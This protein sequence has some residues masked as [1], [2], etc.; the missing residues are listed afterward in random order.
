GLGR[1]AVDFV[2]QKHVRE[3][4]TRHEG[5]GAAAGGGIF[6]DDVGA[7]DVGRHKVRRELDALEVQAENRGDGSHQKGL[8]STG[9][10][11]DE[12]VDADEQRDENLFDYLLLADDHA[13][14]L[15]DDI[16]L[17]LLEAR[18]PVFNVDRV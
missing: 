2:S 13:M 15:R 4:G 10:S 12:T 11:G 14:H 16:R 17:H 7:G 18:N 3:N 5:P 8:S 6:F 1:S 9:Q